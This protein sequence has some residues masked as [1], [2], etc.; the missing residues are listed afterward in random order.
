MV[1][2]TRRLSPM[3]ERVRSLDGFRGIAVLL[4]LLAHLLNGVV[5]ANRPLASFTRGWVPGG[6]VVGVQMF[7]V[8]SGYL[9][10]GILIREVETAGRLNLGRFWWRRLHRLYPAMLVLCGGFAVLV[11]LGYAPSGNARGQILSAV[12]YTTNLRLFDSW[13]WLG[14]LWSLAV[15][16]QFYI[17]WPLLVA[18]GWKLGGRR[19]VVLLAMLG[20]ALTVASRRMLGFDDGEIYEVLRWDAPLVGCILAIV[21][22]RRARWFPLAGFAGSVILFLMSFR[23][24]WITEYLVMSVAAG[25]V[26]ITTI[27]WKPLEWSVLR[28]FGRISYSLYLWHVL[29]L[30]L[31]WPGPISLA[32]S[33]AAGDLSYRFV[34]ER[35]RVRTAAVVPVEAPSAVR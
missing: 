30:R 13:G 20:I 10:T 24:M 5:P 11:M 3:T 1:P 9:I 28:Y 33:I 35:F 22:I 34:E 29:L 21:P 32:V 27:G 16:E 25:V 18:V 23:K 4:V 6:G 8:L 2:R 7:F 17:A 15:E 19:P 14:H 26:M 31:G 12:T